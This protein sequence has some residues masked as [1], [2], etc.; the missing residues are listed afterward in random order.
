METV[1]NV[2]V[3]SDKFNADRHQQ[4]QQQQ[5]DPFTQVLNNSWKEIFSR[6]IKRRTQSNTM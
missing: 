5:F 1:R 4:Q 3:T 6:G 2:D